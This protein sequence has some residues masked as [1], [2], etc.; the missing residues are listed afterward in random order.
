MGVYYYGSH[1]ITFTKIVTGTDTRI[2]KN[3]WVDFHL[4][5]STRPYLAIPKTQSI[6]VQL[7][8]SNK[9]LDL[10]NSLTREKIFEGS[11]G[12]WEFYIDLDKWGDWTDAI[13]ALED[14]FDG[15][16]I[17]VQF[18]DDNSKTTY[19]GMIFISSNTPTDD[20]P[21]IKLDYDLNFTLK[22]GSDVVS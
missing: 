5:P 2:V 1:S 6:F 18:D 17:L 11:T 3:S 15:S 13:E 7:P 12:S 9:V 8:R 21:T 16:E 10:T 4:V 14:Y 20:Y 22:Y 19:S